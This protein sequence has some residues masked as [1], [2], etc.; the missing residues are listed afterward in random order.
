MTPSL[1]SRLLLASAIV[2]AAFLGLT[3][4]AIDSAHRASLKSALQEKLLGELYGLMAAADF[5]DQHQ[6]ELPPTLPQPRFAVAGSGLYA[7]VEDETGHV[8]WRS[9]SL[10]GLNPGFESRPTLGERQV[11]EL[12]P[13]AGERWLALSFG[14]VWEA[15]N[16]ASRSY[17][18]RVMES[19]NAHETEA[20]QFRQSLSLWLAGATGLLLVLQALVLR[21]G[22][23]PLRDVA[24]ELTNIEAGRA[25]RLTG[26]YPKEI[27]PLTRNLNSLLS[28][29]H[30][31]LARY[32]DALGNLAHS[33]KTPLA[34]LAGA[35]DGKTKSKERRALGLEQLNRM[36]DIVDYQLQR[37]AAAGR[38]AL[39]TPLPAAA[40][41]E[42]ILNALDKVYRDKGVAVEVAID[43]GTLF[44]GDEGDLLEI[45]GNLCDNA[46]KWA[47]AR[48]RVTAKNVNGASPPRFVFTVED[49]GPGI[50]DLQRARL[51]RRGGR[52]DPTVPGHG[53]GLAV[54][55][56]LVKLYQGRL[57]ISKSTLGGAK[58]EIEL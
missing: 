23:K 58:I 57:A 8:L 55:H 4:L 7:Q 27:A 13:A 18:F 30:A 10:V 19:L 53:L 48:V 20:R 52:A 50:S 34:V 51:L 9:L 40:R 56:E 33:L 28:S 26:I 39:A 1:Q 54:V 36:N 22:L 41:V 21:A 14:S 25:S 35:L 29:T 2:L 16:G 43:P 32:R 42:K 12:S 24:R 37:A 46:F 31:H 44:Q 11:E 45:A 6:L 3:G 47:R 5:N 49:D 38:T 17:V 15:G